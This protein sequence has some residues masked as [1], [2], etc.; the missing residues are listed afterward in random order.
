MA[1][2][3]TLV[4]TKQIRINIHK[5]NNAKNTVQKIQNT[6][7]TNIYIYI[8]IYIYYQNTHTYAHPHI[9]STIQ[10]KKNTVQDVPKWNSHNIIQY[11]Q[12]KVTLMY[13]ALLS[14]RTSPQRTSL[15]FKIKSLHKNHFRKKRFSA[16]TAQHLKT[17]LAMNRLWLHV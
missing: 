10:V 11:P 16:V 6:L 15:H 4:P 14:P 5:R 7:N 12:Y 13:L 8:Y 9:T 1:V 17:L 2:V 3:L